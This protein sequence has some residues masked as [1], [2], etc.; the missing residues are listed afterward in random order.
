MTRV[1]RCHV[2]AAG[3]VLLA[4]GITAASGAAGQDPDWPCVQRKVPE[5]SLAQIWTGPELPDASRNWSSDKEI[6][7][8][9]TELSA[10]RVPLEEA[11]AELRDYAG[12]LPDDRSRERMTMLVRGLFDHMNAERSQIISGI[13]R[14]ARKQR[15]LADTLRKQASELDAMRG[16][17]DADASEIAS[18]TDRLT[19]QTRIFDERVKSLTYV[20]EVPTLIEQRL[21]ALARTVAEVMAGR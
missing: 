20:C 4:A 8:L 7:A 11:Q 14:Y 15:E 9:V 18:R 16:R 6:S 1:K 13:A 17:Q 21:Y 10:R 19:W 5:L 3:L 12:G 2:A